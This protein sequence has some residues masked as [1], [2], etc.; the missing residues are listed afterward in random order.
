[1]AAKPTSPAPGNKVRDAD[2]RLARAPLLL[3]ALVALVAGVY[4]GLLR[5]GAVLPVAVQPS[6]HGPLMVAGFFATVIS[7]ERAVGAT[8]HPWVYAAPLLGVVGSLLL[9]LG[10]AMELAQAAYLASAFVLLVA[11]A[12]LCWRH[13]ALFTATMMAG[14]AA[15]YVGHLAWLSGVEAHTVTCLWMAFLVATIAGERLELSRVVPKP[16]W[17]AVAFVLSF[18]GF[19]GSPLLGDLATDRGARLL[20][21]SLLGLATW[22]LTFDLARRT[23]R[24]HGQPR[25]VA[26]ALLSGFGWLGCSGFLLLTQ[27]RAIGPLYDA[28]LH[29]VFLGFVLTMI[30]AHAPVIFPSVLGL[31]MSFSPLFYL[32][33]AALQASVAARVAG[34]L[35]WFSHLRQAG[36]WGNVAAIGLFLATTVRA[37]R[38]GRLHNKATVA[39]PR[40][41]A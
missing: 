17:A 27:G 3:G 15:L 35:L 33:L 7:L 22:L 11:S 9:L 25:Y 32:P 39:H 16:R 34:D 38:A 20:G 36:V 40:Q 6:A 30:F 13:P 2:P 12:H 31:R 28:T 18:A 37:I 4:A 29:A 19:A 5:S 14:A 1:M 23:V 24:H 26:I 10:S 41:R 21:V 8:G